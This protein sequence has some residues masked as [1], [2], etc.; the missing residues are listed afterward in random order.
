MTGIR[1]ENVLGYR[2]KEV[3]GGQLHPRRHLQT[4]GTKTDDESA[5]HGLKAGTT[6]EVTWSNEG[7]HGE[8]AKSNMGADTQEALRRPTPS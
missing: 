2:I 7:E 6:S 3:E 5:F 1:L 4:P 8:T